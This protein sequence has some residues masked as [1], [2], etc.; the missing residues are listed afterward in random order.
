[1]TEQKAGASGAGSDAATARR[2][3]LGLILLLSVARLGVLLKTPLELYPDE[4]QYWLWSRHLAFGY[5]SKPPMVAWLIAL[6]TRLG[7]DAEPYVRASAVFL[8]AGTAACL[9]FLGRR[10]YDAWSGALAAALFILM[11]GVALSSLIIATDTPLLFFAALALLAYAHLLTAGGRTRTMLAAG[12]GLALGLAMLSKYAALYLVGGL[13]LHAALAPDA[14]RA[15]TPPALAATVLA[16]GAVFAPNLA[17]N[18]QHH[19]QTLIHTVGNANLTHGNLF[20]PAN[21]GAFLA[22]Q[23]GVFGPVPLALLLVGTAMKWRGGS[24]SEPDRL[25]LCMIGPPL[26]AVT[27]LAFVSRANANWAAIAYPPAAV[28][29]AAW[30]IRWRTEGGKAGTWARVG[31]VAALAVQAVIAGLLMAVAL[32]PR[33]GDQLGAANGLKRMRGWKETAEAV[34]SRAVIE[35]SI[36]GLTAVAVDDRLVFNALAYYGRDYFDREGAAPLRKWSRAGEDPISQAEAEAG[37][38][39]AD[40]RRVLA[41]SSVEAKRAPMAAD[42]A[43]TSDTQIQRLF[44]DRKHMRRLEMFIGEGFRVVGA[45][46]PSGGGG[47]GQVR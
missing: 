45:A 19:F 21:L 40:G 29:V 38:T 30:L 28:L 24:L 14:R 6:T 25:L 27:L 34:T 5:F 15:W 42:F 32:S 4:A 3:A 17:W 7:G 2:A 12:L 23:F 8:N 26:L 1:M 43:A 35:Q 10:L 11:P 37:L 44:L 31:I 36:Q 22:G 47:T 18:A 9:F 39:P 33:L 20:S 16:F 46:K 13:V 41:V